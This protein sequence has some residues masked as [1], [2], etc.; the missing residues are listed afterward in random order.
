MSTNNIAQRSWSGYIHHILEFATF[1]ER[2]FFFISDKENSRNLRSDLFWHW[3]CKCLQ[4]DFHLH[5]PQKLP[6]GELWKSLFMDLWQYRNLW[7]N[8]SAKVPSSTGMAQNR[9]KVNVFTRFRP[10]NENDKE[11]AATDSENTSHITL[12]LHQ[13]LQLI[14]YS[15][16]LTS[17]AEALRCLR[18]EGDWFG[19]KWKA[20]S[21]E[22]SLSSG[23]DSSKFDSSREKL[24]SGQRGQ[25]KDR[26]VASV[27]N[28]DPGTGRVVM[29]AQDVG[30]REFSFD[31]VFSPSFSQEAVYD[32][33]AKR[34]V[35]DFLNGFNASII[36][37]G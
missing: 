9:F 8:P 17:N 28:L 24:S 33:S 14:K 37:Y 19:E 1:R 21:L 3:L 20:L 23:K 11:N 2:V 22:E 4:N 10:T 7:I 5:I 35:I 31:G 32:T 15:K 34:L 12:P 13:R 36:V 16:K 6:R 26:L 30:L 27:Q 18:D 25:Q 29:V